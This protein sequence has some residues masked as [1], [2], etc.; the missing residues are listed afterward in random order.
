[1]SS[2]GII[3]VNP[4]ARA[5]RATDR[6]SVGFDVIGAVAASGTGDAVGLSEVECFVAVDGV[7]PA[8]V[9]DLRGR[10]LIGSSA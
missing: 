3:H 5:A 1:L 9:R 10:R 4:R 8:S 2:T 6:K 7:L